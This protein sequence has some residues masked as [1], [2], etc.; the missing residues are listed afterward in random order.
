MQ[1]VFKA[2]TLKTSLI[3]ILALAILLTSRFT[4]ALPVALHA[5]SLGQL[6]FSVVFGFLFF[7]LLGIK[8]VILVRRR[9]WYAVL[10]IALVYGISLLF[11]TGTTADHI[12]RDLIFL[13]VFSYF[14]FREYFGIQEHPYHRALTVTTLTIT[15]LMLE[16]AWGISLLPL[17]FSKSASMLTLC[18]IILAGI[19]E[20]Y[21][22]GTLTA[23]FLRL[24]LVLFVTL[25]IIVFFSVRWVI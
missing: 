2:F 25:V 20:R 11:F 23:R 21:I 13:A 8:N 10:F 19:I 14:L 9:E 24:T 4:I 17:G 16:L 7:I 1:P 15:V 3:V 6:L 5:S 12:L 22:R 18:A